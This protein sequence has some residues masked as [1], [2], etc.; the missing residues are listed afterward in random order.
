[1]LSWVVPAF[2]N[3]FSFTATKTP[4]AFTWLQPLQIARLRP[5]LKVQSKAP[6]ELILRIQRG[7]WKQR[8]ICRNPLALLKHQQVNDGYVSVDR[9]QHV[10]RRLQAVS[11]K[12]DSLNDRFD[13]P[14]PATGRPLPRMNEPGIPPYGRK[15]PE[16]NNLAVR[17]RMT[18]QVNPVSSAVQAKVRHMFKLL[19]PEA[20]LLE[21]TVTETD[22]TNY[23][24]KLKT[25]PTSEAM[26]AT[27]FR[28][29]LSCPPGSPWNKS[30][31]SVLTNHLYQSYGLNAT[32]TLDNQI[33]RA[34]SVHFRTLQRK[35]MDIERTRREGVDKSK[36]AAQKHRKNTR[37]NQVCGLLPILPT[38]LRV[39]QTYR[40]RLLTSRTNPVLRSQTAMLTAL[41]VDGTSSD[42]SDREEPHNVKYKRRTQPYLSQECVAWKHHFDSVAAIQVPAATELHRG[43][44]A[45]TRI[46]HGGTPSQRLIFKPGLPINAYDA[47]WLQANAARKSRLRPAPRYDFTFPPEAYEYV[48]TSRGSLNDFS[49]LLCRV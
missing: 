27:N 3:S 13:T 41:G 30:A 10:E 15:S 42:D 33:G 36:L 22:R 49:H 32:V 26:D 8:F 23:Q 40:K 48:R 12:L 1:M 11:D 17:S 21:A 16:K 2:C 14:A 46:M 7:I 6:V 47:T 28:I 34:F 43:N 31:K 37:R 35:R 24:E 9:L 45:R 38:R 5:E 19:I 39:P 18:L 25:D 4:L 29:D 44:I 20:Q